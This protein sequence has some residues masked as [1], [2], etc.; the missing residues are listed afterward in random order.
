[1]WDSYNA[2]KSGKWIQILNSTSFLPATRLWARYLNSQSFHCLICSSIRTIRFNKYWWNTAFCARPGGKIT[3]R[4]DMGQPWQVGDSRGSRVRRL[5]NSHSVFRGLEGKLSE[6]HNFPVPGMV[7]FLITHRGPR[8]RKDSHGIFWAL[9]KDWLFSSCGCPET[10][11]KKPCQGLLPSLEK[12][13]SGF[14]L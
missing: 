4:V 3:D 8:G 6:Y 12:L 7:L 14:L 10:A 1:M 5:L 2:A 13:R 11:Q 9:G